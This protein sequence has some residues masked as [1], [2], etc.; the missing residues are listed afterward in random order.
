MA[1]Q[2]RAGLIQLQTNGTIQDAKGEFT[3]NYGQVKRE[4]IVGADG[5]HGYK[6]TPQAGMIKGAITDRG[7]LDVKALVTGKD[8]TVTL[9][10][11][12][13]KVFALKDAWY[14]GDGN[15]TTGEAEIEVEWKG[16]AEEIQP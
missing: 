5:I 2:R 16:T 10:F 14:S 12:N 3:V 15:L 4:E 6:E 1:D 8:L 11:A 13:G 7:T 9:L